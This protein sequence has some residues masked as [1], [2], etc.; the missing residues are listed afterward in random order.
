MKRVILSAVLLLSILVVYVPG[1]AED[2]DEAHKNRTSEFSASDQ[3][4]LLSG[5]WDIFNQDAG[6]ENGQQTLQ[7]LYPGFQKYP[8]FTHLCQEAAGA[9]GRSEISRSI[10]FA[11]CQISR[12]ESTDI[13][14][15][16]HS[17]W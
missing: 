16:Y 8:L 10:Y 9:S 6:K 2:K 11:E 7:R 17:Y 12:F 5:A 13:I 14:Y 15:P 1:L 4:C 3:A